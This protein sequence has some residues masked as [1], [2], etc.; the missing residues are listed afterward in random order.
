MYPVMTSC[1]S[2]EGMMNLGP[3]A[4]LDLAVTGLIPTW[5]YVELSE[6]QTITQPAINRQDGF[7]SRRF[8]LS[9]QSFWALQKKGR[10][11]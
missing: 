8:Q 3:V 9:Y 6:R 1:V 11:C 7:S 4:R 2:D 10:S 5:V